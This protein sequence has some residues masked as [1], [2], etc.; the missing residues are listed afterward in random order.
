MS[1][2]KAQL[3]ATIKYY[4]NLAIHW[5]EVILTENDKA[6]LAKAEEELKEYENKTRPFG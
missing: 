2:T 5:P 1:K 4:E 6:E 3:E